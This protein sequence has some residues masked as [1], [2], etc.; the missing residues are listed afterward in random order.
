MRRFRLA[1]DEARVSLSK[2]R[3]SRPYLGPYL[4]PYLRPYLI[5]FSKVRYFKTARLDTTVMM[6]T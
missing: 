6:I 1:R 5:L 2:V 3:L 4:G